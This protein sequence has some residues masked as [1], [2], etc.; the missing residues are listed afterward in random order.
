MYTMFLN[1]VQMPVTPGKL[2][3]KIKGKNK[4]LT[5]V[6]DGD[7]NFLKLPGLT[8]ISVEV[9][10]P[11]LKAYSFANY[12]EGYRPPHYYLGLFEKAVVEKTPVWFKVTR[13]SPDG[14]RLLFDTNMKVSIESY[15]I[16]ED[17]NE[18]LDVVGVPYA[19]TV[20]GLRHENCD[21]DRGGA[22]YRCGREIPGNGQR[23]ENTNLH[24]GQRRL[25]ME[26]R[27]T[28]LRGRF[29]IPQNL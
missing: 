26:H 24:R 7:V 10:L 12:P 17:A 27:Q 22:A 15:D 4:T 9:L 6:N 11:M 18:G 5:L 8:E 21:R 14:K 2:Q 29:S 16:V 13:M 25:P 3:L 23:A 1:D 28:V 20:Q 19:Q